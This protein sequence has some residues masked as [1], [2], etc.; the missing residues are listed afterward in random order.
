MSKNLRDCLNSLKIL[1]E[2]KCCKLKK[3][4]LCDLAKNEKYFKAIFE[5]VLNLSEN[6]LKLNKIEK[7]KLK[8]HIKILEKILVNPKCRSKRVLAVKQSGGLLNILLPVVG[9][10]ITGLITDVIRKKGDINT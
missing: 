9:S 4:I 8:K 7:K 3:S 2:T 5:I 10:L 1:D 6:K